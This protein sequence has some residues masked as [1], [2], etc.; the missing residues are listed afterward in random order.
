[1]CVDYSAL[2]KITIQNRFPIPRIDDILDRLDG[3]KIFSRIDL[4]SG[5]H[6]IRIA[7]QDIHKTTFRIT[8]GLYKFLMLPFGLTDAPATFNKMMERIFRAHREFTSTFFDD[9]LV[10]SKDE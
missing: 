2:N 10:H 5:Y 6:R 7:P 8:F 4:K 9:I 3:S 1:M